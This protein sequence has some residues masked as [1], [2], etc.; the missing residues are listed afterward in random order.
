MRRLALLVLVGCARPAPVIRN[1]TT[2]IEP[3]RCVLPALPQPA[4][5]VGF[6]AGAPGVLD[7]MV[8]KSDAASILTEL[9]L[10]RAWA[11]EV[12]RCVGLNG[13]P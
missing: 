6:P 1:V 8:T 11:I 3:V 5:V 4:Q 13:G 7:L 9:E 10:L 12:T 2:T